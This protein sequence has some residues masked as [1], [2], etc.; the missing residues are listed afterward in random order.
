MGYSSRKAGRKARVSTTPLKDGMPSLDVV[1]FRTCGVVWRIRRIERLWGRESQGGIHPFAKAKECL[2]ADILTRG[3]F[4]SAA[5][6]VGSR[7]AMMN[8]ALAVSCTPEL[9]SIINGG[10]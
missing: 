9:R 10:K 5:G 6:T 1:L 2:R 8:N 3:G 4:S 7:W